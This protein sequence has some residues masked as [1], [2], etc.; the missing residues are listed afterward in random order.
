MKRIYTAPVVSVCE[1]G[2]NHMMAT[3]MPVSGK[4]ADS[5]YSSLVNERDE[6]KVDIWGDNF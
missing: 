6:E 4:P 3:S 5:G 2:V 1:I